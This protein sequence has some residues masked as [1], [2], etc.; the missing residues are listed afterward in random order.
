MVKIIMVNIYKVYTMCQALLS[1]VPALTHLI[2]TAVLEVD[3][4]VIPV[5]LNDLSN[6]SK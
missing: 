3:T 6:V 5:W 4:I 2:L 1:S